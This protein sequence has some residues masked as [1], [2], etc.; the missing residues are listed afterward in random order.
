MPKGTEEVILRRKD[1]CLRYGQSLRTI[2][3]YHQKGIIPPGRYL[4][5]QCRPF[6]YLSEIE[7]NELKPQ[8]PRPR[9]G[10]NKPKATPPPPDQFDLTL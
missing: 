1:L 9:W 8:K 4:P 6:W 2:D 3:E 5:G 7:A 10:N